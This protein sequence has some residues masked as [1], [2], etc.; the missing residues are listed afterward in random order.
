MPVELIG[1]QIQIS[2]QD[3]AK[4]SKFRTFDDKG[5]I[6]IISGYSNKRWEQQSYQINTDKYKSKEEI[7]EDIKK[8]RLNSQQRN[9][10][11]LKVN[12]L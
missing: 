6:L 8:L 7:K 5:K 3:K 2:I 4:F 10:A 11:I 9:E 1:N 12:Q